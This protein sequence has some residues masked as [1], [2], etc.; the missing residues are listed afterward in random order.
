[1]DFNL[2]TSKQKKVYAAIESF[3]KTKG[4][5]PTVREIG[6]MVGEKTPG[7]VQGI[8]NRLEQKGVIKREEGMARSIQLVTETSQYMQPAY[9]PEIRKVSKR[10]IGDLLSM[11]NINRYIPLPEDMVCESKNC[12]VIACPDDSHTEKHLRYEDMLVICTDCEINSGDMVLVLYENYTLLR[13]YFS[14]ADSTL[15]TLKDATSI[16]DKESFKKDEITIVGKL[17]SKYTKFINM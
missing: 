5:P 10:N 14:D 6:E 13:Q 7:A 8:L 3:I 2:L 1:M 12:F 16:V 4:I 17:I 9:I 15:I 11:Y